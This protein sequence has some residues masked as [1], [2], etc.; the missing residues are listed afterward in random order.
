MLEQGRGEMKLNEPE[1]QKLETQNSW[2]Q[3][4]RRKL[5]SELLHQRRKPLTAVDSQP[6]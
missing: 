3:A 5:H 6:K 1:R 2:Q 4:K